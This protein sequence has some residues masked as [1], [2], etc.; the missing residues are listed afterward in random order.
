MQISWDNLKDRKDLDQRRLT[1]WDLIPL[2]KLVILVLSVIMVHMERRY[3]YFDSGMQGFNAQA[4]MW[5]KYKRML[6]AWQS[7][8]RQYHLSAIEIAQIINA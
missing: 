3:P 2:L 4:K 1:F 6:A 7:C 5:D 8:Q